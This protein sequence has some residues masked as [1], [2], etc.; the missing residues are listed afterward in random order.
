M[1]PSAPRRAASDKWRANDHS[2]QRNLQ[3]IRL[4]IG[5]ISEHVPWVSCRLPTPNDGWSA[6]R[7]RL[8]RPCKAARLLSRKPAAAISSPKKSSAPGS[9][10]MTPMVCQV[11][12]LPDFS[13]IAPRC[14]LVR[15]GRAADL[16]FGRFI[17]SS[18]AFSPD[19]AGL[20][21]L[22]IFLYK[23]MVNTKRRPGGL[24]GRDGHFGR[25]TGLQ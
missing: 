4:S 21:S 15:V 11:C 5:D 1:Q 20:A 14:P 10:P 24:T 12:A 16:L 25:H 19:A 18:T 8:S 23:Y 13:N 7:P 22:R 17:L 2:G 3:P 6:A 9:A